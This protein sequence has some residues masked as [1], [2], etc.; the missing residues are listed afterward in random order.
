MQSR[1]CFRETRPLIDY[2]P[3][4]SDLLVLALGALLY[5]I[6]TGRLIASNELLLVDSAGGRDESTRLNSSHVRTSRMPSSA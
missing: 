2:L 5:L 6:D 3:V 1:E 4:R